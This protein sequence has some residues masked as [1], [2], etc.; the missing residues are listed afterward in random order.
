M[1]K[2]GL[3]DLPQRMINLPRDLRGFPIPWFIH[4]DAAGVPDFRVIGK[5]KLVDAVRKRLCWCCGQSL[6]KHMAFVIGPMCAVNRVISEPP[7]HRDCAIFAAKACPFLANPRMRRLPMDDLPEGSR[8][9][10]GV[11]LD[12]NPGATCVWVTQSYRIWN[13]GNGILFRLGVPEQT[14]WFCQGR[15]ATRAEVVHSINAGLP[16]LLEMA[17]REPDAIVAIKELKQQVENVLPLLP[18]DDTPVEGDIVPAHEI[19]PNP[20]EESGNEPRAAETV[21]DLSQAT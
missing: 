4:I 8:G 9:A 11:P 12:R 6:G 19:L 21:G 16:T 10:A 3:P 7:S 2:K 20:F 13:V 5:D 1:L 15:L 18:R 17:Q 14:L